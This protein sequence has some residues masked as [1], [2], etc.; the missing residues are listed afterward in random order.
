MLVN[1]GCLNPYRP[2]W[3]PLTARCNYFVGVHL[4]QGVAKGLSIGS[5]A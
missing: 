4:F 5:V 3:F 1:P 2:Q